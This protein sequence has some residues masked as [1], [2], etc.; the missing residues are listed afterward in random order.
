V[1][2]CPF[3]AEEIQDEAIVCKHCG[4]DLRQGVPPPVAPPRVEAVVPQK[5]RTSPLAWGCLIMLGLVGLLALIGSLS[6]KTPSN[7]PDRP[8][9]RVARDTSDERAI[10]YAQK[11]GVN[12]RASP[13]DQAEVTRKLALGERV[14]VTGRKG[15]WFKLNAR[16]KEEWIHATLL[17]S[18]IPESPE[19]R[20]KRLAAERKEGSENRK[21]YAELLRE[22]FLDAGLDIKVKASGANAERLTFEYVLFTDVWSHRFQKDGILEQARAMGFR[23]VDMK[24]GYN[25]HVYWNFD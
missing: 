5:R 16:G 18:A 6:D 21:H 22:R 15:A 2:K 19:E 1:K 7:H 25:Y 4:R 3:C 8:A 24:D 10:L 20:R 11:D 14:I 23:R 9:S 13:S 17:G 12:V